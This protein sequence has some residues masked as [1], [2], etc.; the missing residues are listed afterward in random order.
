M[1]RRNDVAKLANVAP[2]TVSNVI[3]GTK[4][5]SEECRDKVEKA[6]KKLNYE[7]NLI[8][9]SLK[10]NNTKSIVVFIND[11]YNSY[12]AEI[13]DGILEVA[14]NNGYTVIICLA[15]D[16]KKEYYN[17]FY[18]RRM[19]G[20]INLSKMF[21]SETAYEKLKNIAHVNIR[22]FD[23]EFSVSINY[24][25]AIEDFVKNLKVS[26][27]KNLGFITG[28]AIEDIKNDTRYIAL[29]HF[30][31]LEGINFD[32]KNIL[33]RQ[34]VTNC[35]QSDIGYEEMEKLLKL[36]PEI[37][38]VFCINDLLAYGAACALHQKDKQIPKDISIC[39]CDNVFFSRFCEPA[40]SSMTFDKVEFGRTCMHL[41][42][43]QIDNNGSFE[44]QHI[45][46]A[47]YVKRESV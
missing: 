4:Y 24:V 37:D 8:A 2:S 14:Y 44:K 29:K 17:E 6:I 3:N 18:S 36:S 45:M 16:S 10:K 22:K 46:L 11:L 28:T 35:N 5:V 42:L 33:Y 43:A 13:C 32:E 47:E 25:K 7:P 27:K 1:V 21:V 23:N 12:Y 41:L 30:T 40:I 39:G 15:N 9:R 26:G 20:M 19:D 31:N 38:A 34:D